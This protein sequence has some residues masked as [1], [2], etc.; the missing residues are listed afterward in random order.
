MNERGDDN[1]TVATATPTLLNPNKRRRIMRN[2]P[3]LTEERSKNITNLKT[4]QSGW[5]S[6]IGIKESPASPVGG[7]ASTT[8]S[9][10]VPIAEFQDC[11]SPSKTQHSY[12]ELSIELC[13]IVATEHYS[14][15]G[16]IK[17]LGN[18]CTWGYSDDAVFLEHFLEL[19]GIQRVLIYLQN[20]KGDPFCVAMASKVLMACTFRTPAQKSYENANAIVKAF[21]K[22]DGI[23]SLL[24]ACSE[25][26]GENMI[27][28][29]E[30][31]RWIW[32]ALMNITDKS[33]A[34]ESSDPVAHKDQLLS[35]F[36]AGL[37]TM[38]KLER[39]AS[40]IGEERTDATKIKSEEGSEKRVIRYNAVGDADYQL[41]AVQWIF[42][43]LCGTS[44]SRKRAAM[45][46]I[47]SDRKRPAIKSKSALKSVTRKTMVA[48]NSKMASMVMGIVFSTWS[49]IVHNSQ[50]V[51]DD[52]LGLGLI[53]K[54][55]A[56]LK[57]PQTGDWIQNKDLLI[58]ASR[59]FVQ[60]RE[61]GVLYTSEDFET[62]FP[63]IVECIEKYPESSFHS[64]LFSFV[65]KAYSVL[66]RS[67]LQSSGVVR[68]IAVAWE[69]DRV[70]EETKTASHQ[71]LKELL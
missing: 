65:T 4:T 33:S 49:N 16:A 10:G 18:F 45:D 34:Y 52:F 41:K 31:L 37:E 23:Q 71:L 1:V 14:R 57:S 70:E 55:I 28:Q 54:C 62:V 30:A 13:K 61:K 58:Q 17:A 26:E 69:S 44:G 29:L 20:N 59:F 12:E 7:T 21:A 68:A 38:T 53:G 3:S 56:T 22:R 60:C 15:S 27:S 42:S 19:G 25:Y 35:V 47:V 8:A 43:S 51:R 36:E 24:D 9:F 5:G 48:D 50:L 39:N 67:F 11:Q 6:K 66:D 32:A 46:M 40:P 64:G 63:L 2:E